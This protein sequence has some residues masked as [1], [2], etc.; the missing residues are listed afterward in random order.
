MT[1][2]LIVAIDGPAASG[3]GT[4]ARRLAA[5]YGLRH[6]DTGLTYRA[7]ARDMLARGER[8]DDEAAA[9][10]AADR[11]DPARLDREALASHAVGNAA[12]RVAIIPAVRRILVEKQRRFAAAPPGA[13]LDGRDIGTVVCPDADIKLF[14]TASPQVR[15]GRRAREIASGGGE[16]RLEDVLADILERDARDRQRT[17]SPLRA[18]DD[19][20]LLDTSEMDI[21]TAFQQARALIDRMIAARAGT[22]K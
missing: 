13:I 10:A 16:A 1:S 12:S 17:D 22:S 15:A 21:E 19:A 2:S 8:L 20:Y 5:S 9:T 7:V 6:L 11:V 4:L 14:V 18:A 3:K